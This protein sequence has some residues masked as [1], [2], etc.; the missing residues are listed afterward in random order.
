MT[1]NPDSV[2]LVSGKSRTAVA[3]RPV[4]PGDM[5]ALVRGILFP[6]ELNE[7]GHWEPCPLVGMALA[8]ADPGQVAFF[9]PSGAIV[10]YRATVDV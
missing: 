10:E 8:R 4:A 1:I 6:A 2:R 7:L 5:V 9:A 3:G